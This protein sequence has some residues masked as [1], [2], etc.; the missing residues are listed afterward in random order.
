VRGQWR[1]NGAAAIQY[2]LRQHSCLTNRDTRCTDSRGVERDSEHANP[3]PALIAL[4]AL[5]PIRYGVQNALAA[6]IDL[7]GII[8]TSIP[9]NNRR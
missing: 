7:L 5:L 3:V 4:I 6:M 9:E 8:P 1:N 2:V